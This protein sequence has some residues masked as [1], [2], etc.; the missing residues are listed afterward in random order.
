M[1]DVTQAQYDA[2]HQIAN[3]FDQQEG[4]VRRVMRDL[5]H[6]LDV[7]QNGA[8]DADAADAYYHEMN[9][10][11]MPGV[12]RLAIALDQSSVVTQEIIRIFRAAEEEA[13]GYWNGT[14][15]G[16]FA[17]GLFSV[18][19]GSIDVGDSEIPIAKNFD[20]NMDLQ[21]EFEEFRD[22][23]QD[24]VNPEV[25][26]PRGVYYPNDSL[27]KLLAERANNPNALFAQTSALTLAYWGKLAS[28]TELE[29]EQL[30][31]LNVAEFTAF[32]FI[33]D[34]AYLAEQKTYNSNGNNDGLADAFRHAYWSA[35][36]TQEFDPDWARAYTDAHE[37]KPGNPAARDYM[38]R[39]NN[40]LGIRIAQEHKEASSEELRSLIYSAIQDGQGVYI[41]DSA[42]L[43]ETSE[44]ILNNGPLARTK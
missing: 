3:H 28:I 27:R 4:R 24:Y 9:N 35:R 29:A 7:L 32:A 33:H 11:V 36:L 5:Q 18:M 2:L 22:N 8:W 21:T 30:D 17:G 25:G 37:T 43:E 16:G 39:H 20:P 31:K 14:D 15:S 26:Y 34:E 19:S 38:D 40:A 44:E 1:T 42:G 6:Q 12:N 13:S 41:P 10:D 23:R